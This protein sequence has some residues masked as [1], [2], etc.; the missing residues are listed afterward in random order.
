MCR[1]IF[2]RFIFFIVNWLMY[3]VFL[4]GNVE[5][6]ES[7]PLP[8]LGLSSIKPYLIG[9][10]DVC[11]VVFLE[12]DTELKNMASFNISLIPG[13]NHIQLASLI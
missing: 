2:S 7:I 10:S 6:R 1:Q 4:E 11:S 9:N 3:V 5:N 13:L 12:G 8:K